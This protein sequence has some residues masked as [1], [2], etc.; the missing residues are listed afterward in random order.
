M[1]SVTTPQS[2]TGPESYSSEQ[3]LHYVIGMPT[4]T[5]P[6]TGTATYTLIGATSPTYLTGG[7]APGTFS[8]NLSVDFAAQ[9][10]TVQMNLNVAVGALAYLINGSA[11]ISG[12]SFS[13]SFVQGQGVVAAN[14]NS[15]LSGCNALVNG[16]FAG[17]TAERAGLAYHIDDAL[18]GKD[19]LGAAAFAKQ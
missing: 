4:P 11:P 10:P 8:G 3:G 7:T 12:N 5:L 13:G 16:F 2:I 15:C 6:Q 18:V 14:G 17:A 19:V 1:G 9:L